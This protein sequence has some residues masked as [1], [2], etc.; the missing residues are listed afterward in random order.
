MVGIALGGL[1]DASDINAIR[2]WQQ[3]GGMY[4]QV[5]SE[6]QRQKT[7]LIQE[8]RNSGTSAKKILNNLVSFYYEALDIIKFG[9][10]W[11]GHIFAFDS[12]S[13]VSLARILQFTS[14]P[15]DIRA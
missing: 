8:D 11:S 3:V 5:N 12:S 6:F 2:L 9:S 13:P 1:P 4:E 7:D 15:I 14:K 10:G